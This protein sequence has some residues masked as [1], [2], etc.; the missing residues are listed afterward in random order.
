MQR[1]ENRQW[2]AVPVKWSAV[3]GWDQYGI[4]R[5][6]SNEA[7]G[8]ETAVDLGLYT[9]RVRGIEPPLRAW[10]PLRGRVTGCAPGA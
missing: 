1:G 2:R 4:R 5:P 10:E 6:D 3:P 7:Q 9:E 8:A